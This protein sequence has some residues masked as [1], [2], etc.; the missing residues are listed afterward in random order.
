MESMPS[1]IWENIIKDLDYKGKYALYCTLNLDEKILV[2]IRT[3]I[4]ELERY[5]ESMT[6]AQN[7]NSAENRSITRKLNELDKM[8]KGMNECDKRRIQG[9]SPNRK[10]KIAQSDDN[11]ILM[12]LPIEIMIHIRLSM[13][14]IDLG[15]LRLTSKKMNAYM[16]TVEQVINDMLTNFETFKEL[17]NE[18]KKYSKEEIKGLMDMDISKELLSNMIE[19]TKI[20]KLREEFKNYKRYELEIIKD[21]IKDKL[22]YYQMMT[23]EQVFGEEGDYEYDEFV[24]NNR[25]SFIYLRLYNHLDNK[26]QSSKLKSKTRTSAS[27]SKSE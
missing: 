7:D 8:I 26:L 3:E 21:I 13:S 2:D 27:R 18:F 11:N 19:T 16:D 17:R 25:L 14:N 15:N 4:E 9:G 10:I 20:Q 24:N 1:E 12:K 5:Y 23:T 6:Y 22:D